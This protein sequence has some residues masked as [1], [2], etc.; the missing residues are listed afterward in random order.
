MNEI[1]QQNGLL[2]TGNCDLRDFTFEMPVLVWGGSERI[3]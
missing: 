1:L 2:I 3:M